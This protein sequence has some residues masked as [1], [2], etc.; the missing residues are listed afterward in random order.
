[1]AREQACAPMERSRQHGGRGW[2][3]RPS[4]PFAAWPSVAG[5]GH[6]EDVMGVGVSYGMDGVRDGAG[7][8][9]PSP[10][11]LRPSPC[12][13]RPFGP[14]A[15]LGSADTPRELCTTSEPEHQQTPTSWGGQLSTGCHGH[16]GPLHHQLGGP[17]DRTPR[18]RGPEPAVPLHS[19]GPEALASPSGHPQA[20]TA[21]GVHLPGCFGAHG[22]WT[23][24]G[25]CQ[26]M[27]PGSSPGQ[28]PR[29]LVSPSRT[30]GRLQS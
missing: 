16:T 12:A 26:Q 5:G 17:L 3:R 18:A 6:F 25:S 2:G 9:G 23:L 15:F 24:L 19:P 30:L 4:P 22:T 27:T 8:A 13:I 10:P 7:C 1:M 20:S 29:G 14:P 28:S 21:T 11:G